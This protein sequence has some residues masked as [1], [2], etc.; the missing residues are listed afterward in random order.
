MNDSTGLGAAIAACVFFLM[1][2]A[3]VIAGLWITLDVLRV[4]GLS[5][6][7]LRKYIGV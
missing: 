7:A 6:I 2:L 4:L 1:W 3:V 5:I